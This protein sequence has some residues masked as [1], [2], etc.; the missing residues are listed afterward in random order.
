MHCVKSLEN[1][2]FNNPFAGK[3][4]RVSDDIAG[5]T[6]LRLHLQYTEDAQLR[7]AMHLSRCKSDMTE[8][9]Q[10]KKYHISRKA[11]V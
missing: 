2:I 8:V 5:G 6:Y 1:L 3:I 11:A 9:F 10:R 7:D 4:Q